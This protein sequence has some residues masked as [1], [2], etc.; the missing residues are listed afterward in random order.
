MIS[1]CTVSACLRPAVLAHACKQELN[2]MRLLVALGRGVY[3]FASCQ[4]NA[5]N[6]A[7]MACCCASECVLQ[8]VSEGE[9]ERHSRQESIA[10]PNLRAVRT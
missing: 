3:L 9:R 5:A 10:A 2:C 7:A 1:T 6:G 8:E 4:R